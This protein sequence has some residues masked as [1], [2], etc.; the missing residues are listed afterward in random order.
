MAMQGGSLDIRAIVLRT[1]M[2]KVFEF[3]AFHSSTPNGIEPKNS[4][5]IA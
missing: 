5:S 1:Q 4:N 3:M 2:H